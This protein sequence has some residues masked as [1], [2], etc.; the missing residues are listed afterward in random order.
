MENLVYPFDAA[1]LLEKKRSLKRELTAAAEGYPEKRIAV[2]SGSTIADVVNML[3]IFLLAEGIRPQFH[4]GTY[5]RYYEDLVFDDGA[6]AAFKPDYLY[7][8]TSSKNLQQLPSLSDSEE[9]VNKKLEAEYGRLETMWKA[10]ERLGCPVIQNNFEWLPYRILGN[11][12]GVDIH[13]ATHFI[14]ELNRRI[15]AYAA[16]H[17]GF[18]VHDLQYLAAREGLDRWHSPSDWYLYKYAM[19]VEQVPN[20]AYSVSRIIKSLLGKNKKGLVLDLDNTLWGGVIGDDGKDHI[21]IGKET[22]AGMAYQDFQYYLKSLAETGIML[23]VSSKNEQ[24]IA[25]EGFTRTECPLKREDFICFK[26]NWEPKGKNLKAIAE[27]INI[28]PEALVFV[29]DNPA[30]REQ[31]QHELPGII[32][33][34]IARPEDS[35]RLL[36][37]AGFFEVTTLSADDKKRNEYYKQNIARQEMEQ[38]YTDYSDYLK[39]LDMTAVLLPFNEKNLERVT[40]LINKTN[41][42]NPT[43]RR[44]TTTETE[45]IAK[46]GEYITL[47]GRLI[48]KFG[49]NGITSAMI[50]HIEEGRC[51]IDVWVMSCRVFKRDFEFAIM[52]RFMELC[53]EKGVKEVCGAFY[54]T[55]KNLLTENLYATMGLDLVH[56]EEK[57]KLFCIKDLADYQPKN[58]VMEI[59]FEERGTQTDE[60]T[61]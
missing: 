28:L 38:S 14:N 58:H 29:D 13:G 1:A 32:A 5:G 36:D 15:A 48:D 31:V 17:T 39:S 19:A 61:D 59:S 27:E 4:S 55:A 47:C 18:Y 16:S 7:I 10:A 20:L 30:E 44:Y 6:L 26:A 11:K 37:H 60:S 3:E 45:Q 22:P 40:Q 56:E 33:P 42:F 12:D 21:A 9:E 43:T 23:N 41:Q 8:H 50:G 51:T 52:D 53:K 46:S 54:P 35:I 34:P 49:D 57:G 2:L 25:L 24:N